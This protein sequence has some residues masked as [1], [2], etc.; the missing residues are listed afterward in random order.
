L[1]WGP[2][3]ANLL[4]QCKT[5]GN[6][7]LDTEEGVRAVA[8]S[9]PFFEGPLGVTFTAKLLHSTA[10]KFGGRSKRAAKICEVELLGRDWLGAALERLHP[11][12]SDVL[13]REARR[14]KVV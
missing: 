4:I 3:K 7:T 2:E 5:T 13:R 6:E 10:R 1:G 9:Q 12:L 14:E 8:G 11:S